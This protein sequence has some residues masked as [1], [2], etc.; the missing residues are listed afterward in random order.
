[1]DGFTLKLKSHI[2]NASEH[3]YCV[4]DIEGEVHSIRGLWISGLYARAMVFQAIQ[5]MQTLL[6]LLHRVPKVDRP[7]PN[8]NKGW[9]PLRS[10]LPK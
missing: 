4:L 10:T 3:M 6:A 1:M 7:D 9:G 5:T 2:L 8:N